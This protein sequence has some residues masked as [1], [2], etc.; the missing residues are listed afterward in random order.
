MEIWVG[1]DDGQISM[2]TD[3]GKTWKNITASIKGLP[4]GAWI[5]QIVLS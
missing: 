4:K 5:P 2:T 1:T 3:H